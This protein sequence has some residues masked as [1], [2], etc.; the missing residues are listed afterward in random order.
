MKYFC[1]GKIPNSNM[2]LTIIYIILAF[3]A[4]FVIAWVININKLGKERRELKSASG[5]LESERLVKETLQKE[6]AVAHQ[7]KMTTELAFTQKLEIA[8]KVIRQMDSDIMLMQKSYEETEALLEAK[9]PEVH[10]LK[11]ELIE[12]KNALARLKG[13]LIEKE[14]GS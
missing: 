4:G 9:H 2:T 7:K 6:L 14:K 11:L 13:I 5:F 8:E 3:I 10:A 1:C 12:V